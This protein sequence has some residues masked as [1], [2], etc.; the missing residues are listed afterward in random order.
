[1]S[2][3]IAVISNRTK[4]PEKLHAD[5]VMRELRKY[6]CEGF[7]YQHIPALDDFS[8]CVVI[9]GDG[10]LMRVA[11]K[12]APLGIP[13]LGVNL[14]RVGYMAE[15]ETDEIGDIGRFFAGDYRIEKRMML[16]ADVA[17]GQN[18]LT[19]LNDAVLSHGI[20]S[21]IADIELICDGNSVGHYRADGLIFATPT[22][23]TAYSLSAGGAVVDPK[24]ECICVTPI[25]PHSLKSKPL[26]FSSDCVLEAVNS[27]PY[28]EELY[29]TVDGNDSA[30]IEGG[31]SV[32]V[33][34][35]EIETSLIRIKNN[36]FYNVLSQKMSE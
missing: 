34:R 29:L 28:G 32:K 21:R 3:K 2:M 36:G 15:L 33:T 17:C 16:S 35:S 30:M 1:M 26:I 10:T 5:A 4:D 20:L 23:S 9:G 25:C 31:S 27:Q 19:A 22:G 24:L 11:R 14:G 18:R 8:L 7:V 13:I 12:A 6:D